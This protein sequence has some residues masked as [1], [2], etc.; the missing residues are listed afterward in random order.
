MAESPHRSVFDETFDVVVFG[1]GYAGYAA[2]LALHAQGKRVLLSGARGDLLWESGR[3]FCPEAGD[4]SDPHW[5]DLVA[6]VVKRGGWAGEWID[7]ALA[8][9]VGTHRLLEIGLPVLYYVRPVAVERA[10]EAVR[11]VVVA[12]KSGLRRLTARRWIDATET[13]ELSRMVDPELHPRPP[14]GAHANLALQH[15]DWNR[16]DAGNLELRTTSWDTERVLTVATQPGDGAWRERILDALDEL[17][18]ALG[19]EI[20]EVTLSHLSVEP[21]AHY[22]PRAEDEGSPVVSGNVASAVPGL[23]P[24]AVRTLA[25]RFE[26]GLAAVAALDGVTSAVVIPGPL[27]QDEFPAIEPVRSLTVDVCV[28]GLGTGGAVA[29][30]T[31]S[32]VGATVAAV[33]P[34]AF[35]GGI[36]TGGGIHGYCFGVAGGFQDEIDRRTR[37]LMNRYRRGP[38]ADGPFNPWAKM[39]ALDRMLRDRGVSLVS[40][41][42]VFDVKCSDG[43]EHERQRVDA[44]LVASAEGVLRMAASSFVD[45]TGDGDVCA[46]AGAS[47]TMGRDY[48]GLQH[49]YT[50]SSGV[51]QPRRGRPRMK[52]VNFDAGF[53][54]ALDSEDLTRARLSGIRQ[55]LLD[56]YD[57]FSRPTYVAAALGVRQS[58]QFE[59]EYVLTMDDQIRRR[60]FDDPI[61]YTG[62][63]IDDHSTDHEFGSDESLFWIWFNRQRM[64]GV[65]CELSYRMIVPRGIENVWIASRCL[66]VTQDAH[67]VTRMQRDMQ[68]IGE[69]AG[70]AAA[71]AA[72]RGDT[73][74]SLPYSVLRRWL[75]QTGALRRRPRRLESEFGTSGHSFLTD[76]PDTPEATQRAR[77]LG[78]LDGGETGLAM[79]WL[80][81]NEA[82][83]SDAVLDRLSSADSTVSWLAA[84]LAAMWGRAAAEPRLLQAITELERGYDDGYDPRGGDEA[85]DRRDIDPLEWAWVVPR[86]LCAV[87]LLRR[88]GMSAS[89]P[90][91]EKLA[92]QP[93]HGIDALATIA[94]TIEQLA[95]A[96]ASDAADAQAT[97]ILDRLLKAQIVG[98]SDYAGRHVGWHSE[99]ALGHAADGD[100]ARLALLAPGL[101]VRELLPNTYVDATW[102][103]HIAVARARIALGR[104]PHAEALR[105]IDDDRAYVRHAA[106]QLTLGVARSS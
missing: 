66:G 54:D 41:A 77:A 52:A 4:T 8:E 25:D 93:R 91:L 43:R 46:L 53:C 100:G 95:R 3:A 9:V 13:A 56:Q 67:F 10:G 90:V 64:V 1:T 68:R 28:A 36:G 2:S 92:E 96:G 48:D 89:L 18:R 75:D 80:Y 82:S 86:W 49:A 30:M 83:V 61:G 94:T 33:E 87:A 51:L 23:A 103:L 17:E 79:W 29:A 106:A 97:A 19:E 60:R 70:F 55:Y 20:A 31:A 21:L 12:T 47:F 98:A 50:Q 24:T 69:A 84:G 7:G 81:Q 102:Q 105:L 22:G 72:R 15:P 73:A 58:R 40:D 62:A 16:V 74:L 85:A 45:G 26:L 27:S 14:E 59:T 6:D 35:A 76:Q 78:A 42:F 63:F 65:G 39:I 44:V 37:E 11:S 71:E 104:P 101:T 99:V 88:C 5:D 32:D 38:L 34:L 57:G